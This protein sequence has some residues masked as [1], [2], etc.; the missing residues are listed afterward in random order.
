MIATE[1][2]ITSLKG[3][4]I[5]ILEMD[6]A[7][8]DMTA[9]FLTICPSGECSAVVLKIGGRSHAYA[10]QAVCPPGCCQ[11]HL[12][13]FL[14]SVFCTLVSTEEQIILY[15]SCRIATGRWILSQSIIGCP[16]IP[17]FFFTRFCLMSAVPSIELLFIL[18][19]FRRA[20]SV[21]KNDWRYPKLFSIK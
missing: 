16:R 14:F 9:E 11:L 4:L 17:D 10:L 3:Y 19:N 21:R 13:F 15:T 8:P 18:F 7:Y 6:P 12:H 2:M 1:K 20:V 5:L